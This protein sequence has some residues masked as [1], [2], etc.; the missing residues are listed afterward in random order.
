MEHHPSERES[1]NGA[2]EIPEG[3]TSRSNAHDA[4]DPVWWLFRGRE[5]ET[6]VRAG[7][8]PLSEE[9]QVSIDGLEGVIQRLE[10]EVVSTRWCVVIDGILDYAATR[11][12]QTL[13]ETGR[14]PYV[15]V[16]SHQKSGRDLRGDESASD[17]PSLLWLDRSNPDDERVARNIVADLVIVTPDGDASVDGRADEWMERARYVLSDD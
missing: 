13:R 12:L 3:D 4:Y 1:H 17:E 5:P 2:S 11:V 14:A 6:Q 10:G 15:F 8:L 9:R 7:P 16:V